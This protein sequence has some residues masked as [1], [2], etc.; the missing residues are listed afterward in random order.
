MG[1][2]VEHKRIISNDWV[3]KIRKQKNKILIAVE[4]KNKTE[5]KYFSNFEN[6]KKSYNITYARGNNTDPLKLVQ[7]LIR[8]IDEL[9]LDL[10]HGDAFYCIFDTD[11]DAHKNK[12]IEKAMQLAHKNNIK[13]I[14]SSPCVELWFLLHYEYT[15]AHMSNEDVIKR[16][17]D[18]YPKYEKNI[19]IYPDII[20][21]LSLAIKNAK[22]LEQHQLDTKHKIGT[23]EA[24]PNTE[25]YK[26]VEYLKNNWFYIAKLGVDLFEDITHKWFT[27]RQKFIRRIF[28]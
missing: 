8:E 21:N 18:Y 3:R 24:N 1:R 11:M 7:M 10:T 12:I 9:K 25:M 27:L 17:K 13:I 4:G 6:G 22:K 2:K 15:T 26:I 28:L 14:T 19:N 5:K 16:L 23:V 20:N